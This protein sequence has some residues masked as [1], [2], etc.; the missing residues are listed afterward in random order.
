MI[1]E[2][3]KILGFLVGVMI[4]MAI[5]SYAFSLISAPDNL[6]VII[7]LV[8]LLLV[9]FVIIYVIK[10]IKMNYCDSDRQEL[11]IPKKTSTEG[12]KK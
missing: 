11:G 7:G 10:R 8:L 1:V 4:A 12:E 9:M 5:I 2:S 3:F 6:S